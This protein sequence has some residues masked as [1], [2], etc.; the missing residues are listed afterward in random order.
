MY[1][2]AQLVLVVLDENIK[3]FFSVRKKIT[4]VKKLKASPHK[5]CREKKIPS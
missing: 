2:R 1:F 3:I 5:D 4:L